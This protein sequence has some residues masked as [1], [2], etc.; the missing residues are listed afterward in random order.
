[1]KYTAHVS[2][3]ITSQIEVDTGDTDNPEDGV[4]MKPLGV[5][6]V[7]NAAMSNGPATLDP[8]LQKMLMAA[9]I[10]NAAMKAHEEALKSG[11]QM[12]N[13]GKDSDRESGEGNLN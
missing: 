11:A 4:L 1:M 2:I 8:V 3:M 6:Y 5:Q 12:T 9:S 10:N 7:G 13:I